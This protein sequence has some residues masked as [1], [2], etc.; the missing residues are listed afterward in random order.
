MTQAPFVTKE[1]TVDTVPAW[2]DDRSRLSEA[3][4]ILKPRKARPFFGRHPWVLDSAVDHVEGQPA[5]GDV[6]D[7]MSDKG[8][9]VARGV[10]NGHSR[11]RVR[12]YTWSA[13]DLLDDDF[14]LRRIRAAA[15]LRDKLGY[16]GREQAVR[17][18]YSEADG[19]SGLIVDR[20][21]E[22]LVVQVTALA[23]EKRLDQLL[24]LL[25]SVARPRGIVVRADR[26]MAK[27]EGLDER[28]HDG[29]GEAPTGPVFIQ[30]HGLK[31]GVELGVGQKTGFYLDQ[32]E[33]RKA[34]AGYLRGCRVLD[35]FCYSGGF[36]LA[37]SALGGASEVLG[38]DSSQSAIALARANAE[39][40]SISNVHFEAGDCFDA[41]DSLVHERR[42][43]DAVILDPPKFTRSR[44]SV[45]EALRAY[46]RINR[47]AVDLLSPGGILV[48]CS[49]SGSVT[50]E[51]LLY[52]LAGVAQ[53]TGRDVQVLQQ[54]GAAQ[55]H[56]VSATCLESEYLKCCICR[57]Q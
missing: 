56:P 31:Y 20:Y 35:M 13:A 8:K 48:T 46:H 23:I 16:N 21:A 33:N 36:S 45:D 57:V 2:S 17:L 37:A 29:W 51:D 6:V 19:L 22:Y 32:R 47:L 12:L 7:L 26:T 10:F 3:Q 27:L 54:R 4:V 25:S 1:I 41:L 5:D 24:P 30:E 9:F 49:C 50:R 18:V 15:E 34:A 28:Q 14:W 42:R 43:F 55:D 38:I 53:Q 44:R 52:V 40:N 39:L 11:I